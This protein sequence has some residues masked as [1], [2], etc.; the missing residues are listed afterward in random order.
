MTAPATQQAG[1]QTW[2]PSSV[3]WLKDV[4]PVES[5]RNEVVLFR[6]RFRG[7]G[8][9]RIRIFAN[10]RYR[11]HVNGTRVA[12]GPARFFP[13]NPCYDEHDIASLLTDG[14]NLIA[15]AVSHYDENNFHSEPLPAGLA[16]EVGKSVDWRVKRSSAFASDT[17]KLSFALQPA[18][19]VDM[20]DLDH[21]YTQHDFDDAAWEAPVAAD[22]CLYQCLA[23]RPI[24][25]LD[26]SIRHPV[27]TPSFFAAE[28]PR[29]ETRFN[30][31]ISTDD[32]EQHVRRGQVFVEAWLHSPR[33]QETSM[34][35]WWGRFFLNG[36]PIKP[37][38]KDEP[39]RRQR[40]DVKL[41][42]GW[43][44]L[45]IAE[46]AMGGAW[47]FRIGFPEEAG[48]KIA[49]KADDASFGRVSAIAPVF[50]DA[51]QAIV[52]YA[53]K[54]TPGPTREFRLQTPSHHAADDRAALRF[55]PLDAGTLDE[56]KS[57]V[58]DGERLAIRYDFGGEFLG[59]TW[60]EFTASA[61]TTLDLSFTERLLDNGVTEVHSRFL[62]DMVQRAVA[63]AGHQTW[64]ALH[65][66]GGRWIELLVGGDIDAFELHD[67]HLTE[68]V[69]D[70]SQASTLECDDDRLK[71][72]WDLCPPTVRYCMEDGF[73]DCPWRERGIY[74]GDLLVE[75][76]AAVATC[77]DT[78]LAR[79]SIELFLEAQGESGLVPGGAF[80]LPPG[81]HP[82]YTAIVPITMHE[83]WKLTGDLAFADKHADR[84]I[85]LLDG[86]LALPRHES[87]VID[88]GDST[89]IDIARTTRKGPTCAFNGF[90]VGALD[91]GARLLDMLGRDDAIRFADEAAGLAGKC[92]SAFW[93]GDGFH[94]LPHDPTS[95]VTVHGNTA[96]VLYGIATDE[97]AVHALDRVADLLSRNFEHSDAIDAERGDHHV[98]SYFS[99][100][101][102]QALSESGRDRVCLDFIK[103]AWGR[104]VD[105]GAWTTWEYFSDKGGVSRCH[106]WSCAPAY[107]IS[108]R[109]LGVTR[110]TARPDRIR[111]RPNPCGLKRARGIVAHPRGPIHVAWTHD[112]DDLR[113]DVDVPDG[114]TL[115]TATP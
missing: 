39:H 48:V 57:Q 20:R 109:L 64:H 78:T 89:Y 23:P 69:Y 6:G 49:S 94:D 12:H 93:S 60:L 37:A 112:G 47:E 104:M 96:A 41:E 114:V 58:Q 62:V 42:A 17:P 10:T 15:V 30:A 38:A 66:L 83:Y 55:R 103:S 24:G 80:G 45:T 67:F 13:G 61:G 75:M 79:R 56:A 92:D 88:G 102:I 35:S 52:D 108:T 31:M 82:D 95:P 115:S 50:T 87:G 68:A 99:Y 34:T 2:H 11:L 29:N 54:G 73:L 32:V 74:A 44:R 14:D 46:Q 51:K 97:Q 59:R 81:R 110:E 63:K 113:L 21:D 77:G 36:E 71:A 18:E 5:R 111:V 100:Y 43:N 8:T 4:D 65:P 70:A 33:A 98:A 85:R 22:V 26:E 106:A 107:W 76:H 53:G 91:R 90:C 9:G 16:V 27:G 19:Y 84:L 101:A 25:R 86:L 7:M 72:V 28:E 105:A 3:L 1:E 40:F